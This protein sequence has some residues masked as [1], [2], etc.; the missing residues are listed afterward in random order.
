MNLH[1]ARR[2]IGD[3]LIRTANRTASSIPRRAR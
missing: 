3:R 2:Y 1:N